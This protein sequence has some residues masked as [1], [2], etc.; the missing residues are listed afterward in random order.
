MPDILLEILKAIS[1]L[2]AI[3]ALI[4]L[5]FKIGEIIF[6]PK[7]VKYFKLSNM[8]AIELNRKIYVEWDQV[9]EQFDQYNEILRKINQEERDSIMENLRKLNGG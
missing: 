2:V 8:N 9:A 3:I 1:I 5:L 4:Y 7:D 6:T